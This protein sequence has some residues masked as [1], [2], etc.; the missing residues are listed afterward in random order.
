MTGKD[1]GRTASGPATGNGPGSGNATGVGS[2]GGMGDPAVPGPATVSGDIT[3]LNPVDGLFLRAEH[4]K[5]IQT[6]ARELSLAVG[7]GS[8]TGV[9]YGFRVTLET[10]K[11]ALNVLPGLAISPI[12][13]PLR[14]TTAAVVSLA[15]DDLPSIGA[16]GFWVV[17]VDHAWWNFGSESVFGN[18]CDE[19]C[20]G[21][22]SALQPWT[23][24]GV[25]VSVRPDVMPGLASVEPLRRRNWLASQYF[26]RERRR[27]G[28]WLVPSQGPSAVSSIKSHDWT[29]GIEQPVRSAVPIGVIQLVNGKWI[30]DVWTARRDIGGPPADNAWRARLAMRPW[31]LFVAQVLQFQDQLSSTA[32]MALAVEKQEVAEALDEA[33]KSFITR[34]EGTAT[35]RTKA[36]REFVSQQQEAIRSQ[37]TV[38]GQQSLLRQQGFDELPPAGLLPFVK[39]STEMGSRLGALFGDKVNLRIC[40]VRADYVPGA[41][42]QAQHLDRIPLAGDGGVAVDI[43]VPDVLADLTTLSTQDYGWVAFVRNREALCD[44]PGDRHQVNVSG[45]ENRAGEEGG[46]SEPEPPHEAEAHEPDGNGVEETSTTPSERPSA[47]RPGARRP[48]PV[49]AAIR[50]AART[51]RR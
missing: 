42:E 17:E 43:L 13:Q 31:N 21:S 48:R 44:Q 32:D 15:T 18:L 38:T 46:G 14:S 39:G 51:R 30:L 3:S 26:E 5:T 33:V 24:E 28:P 35:A 34:V 6:Y 19:P 23:R 10:T 49:S 29:E 27:S 8:G 36:F 45:V 2:G 50:P 9:V 37:A 12:G 1:V 7:T 40:H 22:A 16:D 11:A 41:V 20:S 47:A 25:T 4:L